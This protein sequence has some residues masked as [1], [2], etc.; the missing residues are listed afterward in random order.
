M[1]IKEMPKIELHCHIDGSVRPLTAYELALEEGLISEDIT[2]E[3]VEKRLKVTD[4]CDSLVDYLT[5]FDIPIGIMQ[6]SENIER[7]LYEVIEDA[8]KT[9]VK[10]IELR[11]APHLSMKGGLNFDEVLDAAIKGLKRAQSATGTYA[12][13]IL[14]C[15]RHYSPEKSV[16]LVYNAKKYLNKGVVAIDLAGD[17]HNFPPELHKE[18]FDLA[19]D[20]GFHITVHAGE[21]GIGENITKSIEILH[22]ERIGHG[23]YAKNNKIAYDLLKE[24]NIT[25]E[26]CPTSNI[27]TRAVDS[28][29]NHPIKS[30][31]MDGIK[32]TINTDNMT[33]SNINLNEEYAILEK[34]LKFTKADFQV[35]YLNSVEASF[36]TDEIKKELLKLI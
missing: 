4:K 29:E 35:A 11:F 2:F 30:F 33:V 3:E 18:A 36:A 9:N 13:L 16:E 15:M 32:S 23:V 12:N 8:S 6:K 27:Q 26:M 19:K 24:K 22:A 28:Y 5:K 17:E 34:H 10:Y 1:N 25:L 20:L 7:I 21:T 14:C 31:L